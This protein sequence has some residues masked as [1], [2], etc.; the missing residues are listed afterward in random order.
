M[1]IPLNDTASMGSAVLFYD[2]ETDDH[3]AC[4]EPFLSIPSTSSTMDFKTV[5][6]LA[7]EMGGM[8]VDGINDVFV[9]GT[10]VGRDYD[11]L[12][13]GIKLTY[14]VWMTRVP[15]LWAH[16]PPE[17]ISLLSLNWQP[18]GR[19]WAS[20]SK[21][22]NPV[23]GN[24]LGVDVAKKGT[25]LAWAEV[26]EWPD[27]EDNAAVDRWVR[28]TTAAINDAAKAAG[29]WDAFMYMGDAAGFQDV[30]SGYGEKNVKRLRGISRAYDPDRVFQKLLP[31]GFKIGA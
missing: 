10:T 17:Y 9:A 7:E 8:V 5:A 6:A 14:D 13:K 27:K 4:F 3:P 21:S 29:I 31:G 24:P 19:L 22:S 16:V 30:F 18:I 15:E 12:L 28:E 2:S 26:V 23:V 25:Y 1:V 20:G 11:T